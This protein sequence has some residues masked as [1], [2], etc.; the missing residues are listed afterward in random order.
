MRYGWGVCRCSYTQIW[1]CPAYVQYL[2]INKLEPKFDKYLFIGYP[3][4]TKGYYFY[5]TEEQKVFISSRI[6]FLKKKFFGEETNASKIELGEVHEV[7]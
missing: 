6:I 2:K 5:L 4:E 7:E 1:G 3:K